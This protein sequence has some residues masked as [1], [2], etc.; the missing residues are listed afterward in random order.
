MSKLARDVSA[1]SIGM[2]ESDASLLNNGTMAT[3]GKFV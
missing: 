1:Y 2:M 3:F